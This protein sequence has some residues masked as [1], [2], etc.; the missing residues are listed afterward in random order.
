MKFSLSALTFAASLAV[1]N[2][3]IAGLPSCATSCLLSAIGSSSCDLTDR[4]CICTTGKDKVTESLTS[5]LPQSSCTQ[6]EL[7][8]ISNG[9]SAFCQSAGVN[10]TDIPSIALATNTA[11]A[12]SSPTSSPGAAVVNVAS[13]GAVA[14]GM[15]AAFAL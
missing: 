9:V 10:V 15:V 5:C 1:V 13:L 3:Q 12:T 6:T 2:A 8:T 11:S 7:N 4:K 14:M